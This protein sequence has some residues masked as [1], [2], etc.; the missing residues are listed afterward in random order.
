MFLEIIK[1]TFLEITPISF[2][3]LYVIFGLKHK[4]LSSLKGNFT[5]FRFFLT[6]IK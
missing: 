6:G 5:P 3:S 1:E 4:T 2:L